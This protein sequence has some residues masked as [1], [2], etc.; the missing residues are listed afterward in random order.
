VSK[1]AVWI[2]V[3]VVLGANALLWLLDVVAPGPSGKPS[4]SLA[5]TPG[6]FSGWAELA[7]RN[8]VDVLALRQS[9][10]DAR[11]PDGATVVALDVPRLARADALALRRFA[12]RGGHVVAGGRRPQRLLE[13]LDLTWASAGPTSATVADRRIS[14]AGRGSF[15]PGGILVRRGSLTL[16]ADSS[17]L[18]NARLTKA[19]NAAF[20]LDLTGGGP[21]IFAE[22]AHGYGDARG[23]AA[24][25]GN[26]KGALVL[27][28]VA[29]LVLMLARGRR[30]GPVEPA[31][32]ELAPP[33]VAYVDALAATLARMRR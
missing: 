32:R 27:L 8:G 4:S 22:A 19:D 31:A 25:P 21:L 24:L 28:L 18:Q 13:G 9:L 15:T 17:P 10:K 3:A 20:A 33:R 11:L 14:L 2:L 30:F 12:D 23:L 5:T 29:A 26:A 16:I 1:H 7:K 6:G